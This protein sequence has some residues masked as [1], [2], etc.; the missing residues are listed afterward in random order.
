MLDNLLFYCSTNFNFWYKFKRITIKY[1]CL[2][3]FEEIY[4]MNSD[5]I[6]DVLIVKG[7]DV[8]KKRYRF[9]I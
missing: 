5:Q 8:K 7:R 2:Y 3:R 6:Y 9:I 4:E 1:E